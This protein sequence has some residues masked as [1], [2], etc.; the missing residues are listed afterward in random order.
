MRHPL[1]CNISICKIF[2][3]ID[4]LTNLKRDSFYPKM[5]ARTIKTFKTIVCK[6]EVSFSQVNEMQV[7]KQEVM[8]QA[9]LLE[10]LT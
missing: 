5:T 3:F 1:Q 8:A 4:I 6:F 7:S 10:T 9:K 2:R